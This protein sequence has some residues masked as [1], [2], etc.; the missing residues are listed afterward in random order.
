MQ[1]A[2]LTS[3]VLKNP[4][5]SDGDT[6]PISLDRVE[7]LLL[8]TAVGDSLGLP[9][10]GLSPR[11]RARLF[12]GPWRQQLLPRWG[13]VSDDT[14]HTVFVF[15]A[16]LASDSPRRCRAV[17]AGKLRGWLLTLPPGIGWGTL[18]GILKLWLWI[19]PPYS[20]VY[21][22]GNGPAMRAA[23]FG[24]VR[25]RRQL[26]DFVHHSTILTHRDPRAEVAAQAIALC[27]F[28]ALRRA[29]SAPPPTDL[30]DQLAAL[31]PQDQEWQQCVAH[32]RRGWHSS[33]PVEQVARLLVSR[34]SD[35][36]VSGYAYHSVPVAIYSWRRHWR[37]FE[38]AL[39]AA[40]DCGGDTDT[41][42]AMTGA[43]AGALV[44]AARIPPLWIAELRDFPHGVRYLRGLARRVLD[45]HYTPPPS[46][47]SLLW[48]VPRFL[49]WTVPTQTLRFFF[50]LGVGY[51]FPLLTLGRW[52]ALVVRNL[53]LLLVVL[54]HG[55]RRLFPPY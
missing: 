11:R 18:R 34:H 30:A 13:M 16:L 54:L 36:G 23:P 55:V 42:G 7:G 37:D 20:A 46:W 1:I 51:W 26:A 53:F 14:D 28:I 38:T 41:V 43:L 32:L 25:E 24:M 31:A 5:Q 2:V 49:L 19:P 39:T 35:R 9:T 15:E 33:Q 50:T 27:A 44:G 45:H 48:R 6:A 40:L 4:P 29:D 17:L 52:P 3:V 10:E 21:S 8:G 22:A 12:P 47:I